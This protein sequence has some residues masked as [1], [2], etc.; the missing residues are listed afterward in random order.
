L[1]NSSS[2]MTYVRTALGFASPAPLLILFDLPQPSI[3]P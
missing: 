3:Q 1:A 2:S